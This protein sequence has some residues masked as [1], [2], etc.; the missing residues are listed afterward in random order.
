MNGRR[1]HARTGSS[2]SVAV[3]AGTVVALTTTALLTIGQL[4]WAAADTGSDAA[5]AAPELLGIPVLTVVWA[6]TGV[7]AIV[8]G[9]TIAS[10]GVRHRAVAPLADPAADRATERLDQ[11]R[12][13]KNRHTP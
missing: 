12:L 5:A 13:D 1:G 4:S 7:L 3:R 10:R 6:L 11:N 2:L 8:V 9:M